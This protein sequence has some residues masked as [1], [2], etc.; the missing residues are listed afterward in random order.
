MVSLYVFG[1]AECVDG[2]SSIISFQHKFTPT[3]NVIWLILFYK[4]V[5]TF[6]GWNWTGDQ[7]LAPAR[8]RV[9]EREGSGVES[10]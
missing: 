8:A 3:P 4:D 6:Q 7:A 1:E 5:V 9:A 10:G 2:G